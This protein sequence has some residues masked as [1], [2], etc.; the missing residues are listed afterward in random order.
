MEPEEVVVNY[1]GRKGRRTSFVWY[2][3]DDKLLDYIT[4]YLGCGKSEA[5]RSALRAYAM[6]LEQLSRKS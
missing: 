4:E 3:G 6:H 1:S 2:E 5:V